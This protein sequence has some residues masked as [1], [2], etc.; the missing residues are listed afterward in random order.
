MRVQICGFSLGTPRT[1]KEG[2]ERGARLRGGDPGRAGR[3]PGPG[4]QSQGP[5]EV[6]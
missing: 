5:R 2:E 4:F 1:C 3:E 6:G